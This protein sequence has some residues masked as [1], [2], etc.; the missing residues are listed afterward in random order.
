MPKLEYDTLLRGLLDALNALPRVQ[1]TGISTEQGADARIFLTVGDQPTE[2]VVEMKAHGY[3]RDVTNAIQQIRRYLAQMEPAERVGMIIAPTLTDTSREL[4]RDEGI[5]YWDESGSLFL[6]LH[7]ALYYLERARPRSQTRRLS[8]IY[9]GS[10]SQVVHALLLHPDREWTVVD[11]AACAEVSL[12]TVHRVFTSL[13]ENLWM[14]AEGSN[15]RIKRRL[16]EPGRLLDAWAAAYVQERRNI[17]GFYTWSRQYD[18]LRDKVTQLLESSGIPYA[19]TAVSGATLVA[20]Y[21]TGV[22]TLVLLAPR[23]RETTDAIEGGSFERAESGA[24]VLILPVANRS[25]LLFTQEV[26]GKKVASDVQLYLDLSAWPERGPDQARHLR[27]E[28][29]GY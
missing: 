17:L 18:S 27:A 20:P 22:D 23:G 1:V 3:P 21:V 26:D 24:N 28:R 16:I 9:S 11:L 13:E 4:L 19:L 10:A 25:P 12:A 7:S 15:P 6:D 14:T 2:I 8:T 29:L 5:N